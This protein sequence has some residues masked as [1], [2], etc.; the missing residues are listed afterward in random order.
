MKKRNMR[1]LLE[2]LKALADAQHA[3]EAA[4]KSSSKKMILH[5]AAQES[6]IQELLANYSNTPLP[7]SYGDFLR[8]SDGL[9][10]GWRTLNFLPTD[11][12][13]QK[14]IRSAISRA[15]KEQAKSLEAIYGKSDEAFVRKWESKPELVIL[16]RHPIV[17]TN[18]LGHVLLY[19]TRTRTAKGEMELCWMPAEEAE[20]T[21]RFTDIEDYF[22]SI[23]AAASKEAA[24]GS[25]E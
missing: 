19:D 23:I 9:E 11:P 25:V 4:K 15:V 16:G 6:A 10:N 24:N 18:F 14:A 7:S 5:P 21:E 12:A 13:R 8:A 17:A 1:P 20:I 22:R 3:F 2:K